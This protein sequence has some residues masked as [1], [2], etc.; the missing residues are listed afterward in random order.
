VLPYPGLLA[1][2]VHVEQLA[3]VVVAPGAVGGLWDAP[4]GV[5]RFFVAVDG[6]CVGADVL[7]L[8]PPPPLVHAAVAVVVA[9]VVVLVAEALALSLVVAVAEGKVFVGV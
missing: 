2:W 5:V 7:P 3:V 8:L 1:L 6:V 9:S 4:C